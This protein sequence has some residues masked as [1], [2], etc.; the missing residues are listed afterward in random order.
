[1]SY[2][3]KVDVK[4]IANFD[5]WVGTLERLA[6]VDTTKIENVNSTYRRNQDLNNTLE[7]TDQ[8]NG[9]GLVATGKKL[10]HKLGNWFGGDD[11]QQPA[12]K[13]QP[14]KTQTVTAPT[15]QTNPQQSQA[16]NSD[17]MIQQ[18][19]M[20]MATLNQLLSSVIQGGAMKVENVDA[21]INNLFLK[22]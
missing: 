5:K 11:E 15:V 20:Q 3:A 1:M 18:L 9:G 17:A 2:L 16:S 7:K 21:N 12:T 13:Q 8:A 4:Y 6:N 14:A 10:I 22:K 19:V